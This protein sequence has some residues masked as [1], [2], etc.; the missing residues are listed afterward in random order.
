MTF[1]SAE[2]SPLFRNVHLSKIHNNRLLKNMN[3]LLYKEYLE[4]EFNRGMKEKWFGLYLQLQ[5]SPYCFPARTKEKDV[6][7]GPG[8]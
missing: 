3:S 7:S 8:I 2:S 5:S 1:M 4:K 6:N